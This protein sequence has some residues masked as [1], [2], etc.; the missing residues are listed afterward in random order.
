MD[1]GTI[2]PGRRTKI[3]TKTEKPGLYKVILLNDDYTPR[4]FVVGVLKKVFGISEGSAHWVMLTAHTQGACVV[5]VY[6]R[7]VAETKMQQ[8]VE[9]GWK[10]G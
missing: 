1:N 5:S 7:D 3:R 8:G 4:E 10:A 9:E 2:K 6:T